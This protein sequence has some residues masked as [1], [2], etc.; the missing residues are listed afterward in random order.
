MALVRHSKELAVTF[1][2]AGRESNTKSQQPAVRG[3]DVRTCHVG[4]GQQS[5]DDGRQEPCQG[6]VP[7]L[8]RCPPRDLR[9]PL[10][11]Q[12]TCAAACS[13]DTT[14]PGQS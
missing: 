2:A 11:L 8:L 9:R 1:C 6:N 7:Y 3:L 4:D 10:P 14:A 5:A 12:L 13:T